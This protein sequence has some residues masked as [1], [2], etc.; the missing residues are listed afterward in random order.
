MLVCGFFVGDA[1]RGAIESEKLE[2][3]ISVSNYAFEASTLDRASMLLIAMKNYPPGCS[4]SMV[5][6]GVEQ[7]IARAQAS[8][9]P[10]HVNVDL[11]KAIKRAIQALQQEDKSGLDYSRGC[12]VP[13]E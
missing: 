11:E 8:V 12:A 6:M 4:R 7:G 3:V 2:A 5:Q 1:Y 9:A 13:Y 10:G